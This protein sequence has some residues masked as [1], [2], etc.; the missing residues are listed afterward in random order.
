MKKVKK[1]MSAVKKWHNCGGQKNDTIY[2]RMTEKRCKIIE[3]KYVIP[4]MAKL[5]IQRVYIYGDF[6]AEKRKIDENTF[7]GKG[8]NYENKV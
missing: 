2:L 6:A 5:R 3:Y 8:Q 7:D 4:R 1:G